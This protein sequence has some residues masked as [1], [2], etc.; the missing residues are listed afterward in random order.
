MPNAGARLIGGEGNVLISENKMYSKGYGKQG[1]SPD[2][3][4]TCKGLRAMST[5][6]VGVFFSAV[7]TSGIGR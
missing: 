1:R 6:S 3:C 2:R 5:A 4:P 7:C